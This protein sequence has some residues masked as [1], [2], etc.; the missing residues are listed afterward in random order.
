MLGQLYRRIKPELCF[1]VLPLKMHVDSRFFPRKEVETEP[2][3]AKNRWTH[4]RYDTRK[5]R[6]GRTGF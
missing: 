2:A 5:V 6:S 1:A 4:G 3:L